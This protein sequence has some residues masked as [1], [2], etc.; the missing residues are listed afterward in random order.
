MLI[1]LLVRVVTPAG[2]RNMATLKVISMRL[3]SVTSIQKI[4]KSMKMVS[5]AKYARAERGLK[6]SR[7]NGKGSEALMT[8]AKLTLDANDD[9]QLIIGISS[10]RGLCGGIHS[11]I[12][13]QIKAILKTPVAV[14]IVLNFLSR[15]LCEKLNNFNQQYIYL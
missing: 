7:I 14:I 6:D 12:A 4:T 10:D 3:K 13:K 1:V 8:N 15:F 11:G 9:K 5:A 2:A